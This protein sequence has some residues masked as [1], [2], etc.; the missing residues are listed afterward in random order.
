MRVRTVQRIAFGQR[1]QIEVSESE[2][3][4]SIRDLDLSIG[5]G[6]HTSEKPC[7]PAGF[8]VIPEF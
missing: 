6:N 7:Q 1:G 2:L 4:K 8:F 5:S 3:N